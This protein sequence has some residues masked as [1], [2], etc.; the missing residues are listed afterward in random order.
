MVGDGTR[1]SQAVTG[2]TRGLDPKLK[3]ELDGVGPGQGLTRG[4]KY[5]LCDFVPKG[6][7]LLQQVGENDESSVHF[8]QHLQ[9]PTP[10]P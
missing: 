10:T 5:R 7:S 1:G 3:G 4:V 6:S 8:E 2:R 9:S